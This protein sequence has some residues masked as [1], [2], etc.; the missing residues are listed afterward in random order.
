MGVSTR[1]KRARMLVTRPATNAHVGAAPTQVPRQ[2]ANTKYWLGE[3]RSV[4]SFPYLTFTKQPLE[5]PATQFTVPS[6]LVTM[7]FRASIFTVTKIS[8]AGAEL[9]SI[10]ATTTAA[11]T[12][13][14]NR[15]FSR[16]S[17]NDDL[18][19]WA[20]NIFPHD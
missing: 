1:R 4:T 7:P 10:V 2:P 18:S 12:T 19:G 8:I 13:T 6:V 16:V 15:S 9:G 5:A 3:A 11:A 14:R 17:L 20:L